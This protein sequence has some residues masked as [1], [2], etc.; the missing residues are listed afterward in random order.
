MSHVLVLGDSDIFSIH[1]SVGYTIHNYEYYH[2]TSRGVRIKTR[3]QMK[4]DLT[5]V[6]YL[7]DIYVTENESNKLIMYNTLYNTTMFKFTT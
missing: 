5:T 7:Y 4:T 6:A 2:D 3:K 1:D